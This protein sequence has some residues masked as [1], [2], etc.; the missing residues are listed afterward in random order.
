[1]LDLE[2]ILVLVGTFLPIFGS[3]LTILLALITHGVTRWV[4][5]AV[6]PGV[7]L[8][9]C[10]NIIDSVWQNGN[11]LAAAIFLAY[12]IALYIYY[13]VLILTGLYLYWKKKRANA[14]PNI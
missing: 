3:G 2:T 11:M 14:K 5:L 6:V 9:V 4:I 13:P 10:W 1:M 7:T 8:L 12:V